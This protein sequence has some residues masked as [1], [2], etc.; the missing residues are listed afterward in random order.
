MLFDKMLK[1]D[2][3]W[4]PLDDR[5]YSNDP[6][7]LSSTFSNFRVTADTANRVSAVFACNSLLLETL[8]ATPCDLYRR[9]DNGGKE[10]AKDHPLYSTVRRMANDSMTAMEMFGMMQ[11]HTGLRGLSIAEIRNRGARV[12]LV[13]I[14]PAMVTVDQLP[15]GRLRFRVRDPKA[16][17][18]RT[19]LQDEVLMIRDTTWDGITGQ[20]RASLAREAIAVAAAGEAFVGGFFKNDASGRLVLTHP[21]PGVPE[22][23]LRE[24][25]RD[26]IQRQYAGWKNSRRVM[27]L[28]GGVTANEVG[29]L[30]DGAFIVDPRKFQVADVARYWRVPG[31][32]IGLEEKSTSWGSGLEQQIRGFIA[33]TMRY[34]FTLWQSS[35]SR[36][37]L[38]EDER[39]EYFFEFNLDD[40][41]RGDTLQQVQALA[42]ERMNGALSPDEWRII[43]NRNPREDD[44]GSK[45]QDSPSWAAPNGANLPGME[46]RQSTNNQDQQ[47][48]QASIPEPI[49]ADAVQRIH[50]RETHRLENRPKVAE[51]GADFLAWARTAYADHRAYAE[52]VLAPLATA[53]G[54]S[55]EAMQ[56]VTAQMEAAAFLA[57]GPDGPP[58]DWTEHRKQDMTAR[59]TALFTP[60]S[61]EQAA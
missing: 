16:G 53:Y 26:D 58:A 17:S 7:S 10:K 27:T 47:D 34:W 28:W 46:R 21:G 12:D 30:E 60:A 52:K 56:L 41:L 37:L 38:T 18:E 22:K 54:V 24:E 9:L 48:S 3:N 13:P 5:W 4:N 31:F 55:L 14:H 35:M 45:F 33:F 42:I 6:G 61:L 29:K 36:D 59:L 19:L 11:G 39:E 44:G 49:L 20:A 2:V 32:M 15:T 23:K 51:K 25:F 50:T 1:A 57:M 8:A 40:L 43:R